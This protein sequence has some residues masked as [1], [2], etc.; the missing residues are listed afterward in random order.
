LPLRHILYCKREAI[1]ACLFIDDKG[2]MLMS[3]D[4]MHDM[5]RVI[6]ETV[7]QLIH[8]HQQPGKNALLAKLV[9][10]AEQEEDEARLLALWQARRTLHPAKS[11]GTVH[12]LHNAPAY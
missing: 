2:V 1:F 10:Q 4:L 12:Q 7:L 6:G 5:N 3:D 9:W 11:R 8:E